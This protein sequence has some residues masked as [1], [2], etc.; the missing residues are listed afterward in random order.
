MY[1][2]FHAVSAFLTHCFFTWGLLIILLAT[3]L[4]SFMI[5]LPSEGFLIPAGFYIGRYYGTS[6]VG[7]GVFLLAWLVSLGGS[8]LGAYGCYYFAFKFGRDF[9]A[10]FGKYILLPEERL[11]RAESSFRKYGAAS[12]IIGRI[13]PGVRHF[14]AIPAGISGMKYR[15]FFLFSGI[16]AGFWNFVLLSS[17]WAGGYWGSEIDFNSFM[18][19]FLHHLIRFPS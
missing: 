19:K 16:G 12:L 10:K 5:P 6:V 13:L 18:E 4:E 2:F 14:I 7:C 17:G 1:A 3:A 15:R 11:R 9:L 8:L